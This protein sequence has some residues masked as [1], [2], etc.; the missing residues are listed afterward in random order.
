MNNKNLYTENIIPLKAIYFFGSLGV[1]L[2]GYNT[3]I[4]AGAL[5]AINDTYNIKSE[6]IEDGI[7]VSSL[8]IGATIA[9]A[10]AGKI[11]DKIGR[12]NTILLS[13]ILF[14]ITIPLSSFAANDILFIF[15]RFIVGIAIGLSS[16]TTPLYLSELAPVKKRGSV[17]WLTQLMI[18]I[19]ILVAYLTSFLL[20][21]VFNNSLNSDFAWRLSL[22][23]AIVPAI[24]MFFGARLLPMS[25]YYLYRIG[26]KKESFNVLK[27]TRTS[28]EAVTE[29]NEMEGGGSSSHFSFRDLLKYPFS[30]GLYIACSIAIF[31]QFLGCNVVFYYGPKILES[32]GI[33][34]YQ[35]NFI[36]L[37][38][39]I[40]NL[41]G[42]TIGLKIAD[43]IDRK[44][45][46]SIGALFQM[47]FLIGFAFIGISSLNTTNL[48]LTE[49]LSL[50]F[51]IGYIFAFSISW[52]GSFFLVVSE[53]LDPKIKSLGMAIG[54]TMNWLSNFVIGLFF[55]LLLG[56][57][58]FGYIFLFISFL[59][60]S[61]CFYVKYFL[62]ETRGKTSREIQN[63][64]LKN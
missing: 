17:V 15:A 22:F 55:P 19:G 41:I 5:E 34:E 62:V 21:A 1:F 4:I 3:A 57:L 14:C 33:D 30:K 48:P 59:C 50:F 54:V 18:V 63:E 13:S 27:G 64:I 23:I 24:V 37:G 2:F 51:L 35:Q 49:L 47:L 16:T 61:S 8:L 9:A 26:L 39:G 45:L 56:I 11:A 42:T 40:A 38:I 43:K 32:A 58:N 25:P 53:V 10:L 31:Q 52:G 46:L 7:I 44:K 28:E 29:I 20:F 6:S 12:K 60:L 36:T